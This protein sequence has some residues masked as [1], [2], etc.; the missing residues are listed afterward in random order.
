[1]TQ[2]QLC[3]YKVVESGKNVPKLFWMS[4]WLVFLHIFITDGAFNISNII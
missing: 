3:S 1:M 4:A 2:A